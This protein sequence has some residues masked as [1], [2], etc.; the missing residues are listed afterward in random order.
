[1]TFDPKTISPEAKSAFIA[2]GR[3]FGSEDTLAQAQLTQNAYTHHGP[4]LA[5]H[6]YSADDAAELVDYTN[7]LLSATADRHSARAGKQ[8]HGSVYVDTVQTGRNLRTRAISVARSTKTALLKVGG[9][10]EK[11]AAGSIQSVLHLCAELPGDGDALASQLEQ[12]VPL[13]KNATIAAA[14]QNRGGPPLIQEIEAAVPALRAAAVA[15]STPRG[16]PSQTELLDLLDGL[17]VENCRA[18][19]R[20]ARSASRELGEDAIAKT[21]ELTALRKASKKGQKGQAP[22]EEQPK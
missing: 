19:R 7:A 14:A 18:A 4:A 8:M 3:T 12:F 22:T 13:F 10:G 17:I 9:E 5:D 1:M 15:S 6:G 2:L 16:T 21:F 11:A 20:A